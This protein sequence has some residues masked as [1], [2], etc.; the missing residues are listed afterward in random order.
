MG[1]ANKYSLIAAA[2]FLIS[3]ICC[4]P[5]NDETALR[6]L[7]EKAVGLAEEHDIAGIMDLT[8]KDFKAKP[9]D[10]DR[11]GVKRILFLTFKHYGKGWR[12]EH[13]PS[14]AECES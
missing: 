7:V 8:T 11:I 5:K 14:A 10:F 12:I 9:G 2:I 4:S 13:F 3:F 6:E 1:S